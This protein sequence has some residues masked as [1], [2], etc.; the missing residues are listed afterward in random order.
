M[1]HG[2]AK[3]LWR[4]DIN[5]RGLQEA[6]GSVRADTARARITPWEPA[7]GDAWSELVDEIDHASVEQLP[8]WFT[9]IEGAYGHSPLYFL[10]EDE[11]GVGGVLPAFLVRSRLFGTVVTSM[12]FL[13]AGAPCSRSRPTA[14]APGDHLVRVAA[15]L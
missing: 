4:P 9:A 5:S 2:S 15:H 1:G 7:S 14:P 12:P 11:H 6:V 8:Q 10:G 13:D 3:S